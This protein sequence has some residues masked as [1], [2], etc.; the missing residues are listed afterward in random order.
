M[1]IKTEVCYFSDIRVY[2][3]HGVRMIRRDGQ[4]SKTVARGREHS[5]PTSLT[6]F[7]K[8]RRP[9]LAAPQHRRGEAGGSLHSLSL[10]GLLQYEHLWRCVA[11]CSGWS[12]WGYFVL[13]GLEI[14]PYVAGQR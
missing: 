12:I 4:V 11:G 10:L 14:S 9:V 5:S 7:R 6:I 2:P 3:G 8:G 1:V 13:S